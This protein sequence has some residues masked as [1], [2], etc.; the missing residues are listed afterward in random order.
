MYC[1]EHMQLLMRGS[2]SQQLPAQ[3]VLTAATHTRLACALQSP[4]SGN[5]IKPAAPNFQGLT[6]VRA[7][8]KHWRE[9]CCQRAVECQCP[10]QL[11][12]MG[13]WGYAAKKWKIPGCARQVRCDTHKMNLGDRGPGPPDLTWGTEGG[14]RQT[15]HAFLLEHTILP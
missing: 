4:P 6:D 13:A 5:I 1:D 12:G 14:G 8:G 11:Q 10:S 15:S 9:P 7:N 2:G 3:H